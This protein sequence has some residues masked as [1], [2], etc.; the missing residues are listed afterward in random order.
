MLS[1]VSLRPMVLPMAMV[2]SYC[3]QERSSLPS[4]HR[5]LGLC[6]LARHGRMGT[7]RLR[8]GGGGGGGGGAEGLIYPKFYT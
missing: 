4:G 1:M 7:L 2:I 8:G 6:S 5:T 3:L